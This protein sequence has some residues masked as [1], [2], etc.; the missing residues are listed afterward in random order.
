MSLLKADERIGRNRRQ[1]GQGMVEYII[2]VALVAIGATG[3]YGAFGKSVEQQTTA[4]A[5]GLAGQGSQARQAISGA[6]L[7]GIEA[8]TN[9]NQPLGLDTYSINVME[10]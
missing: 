9:A 8:T 4:I 3:V 1:T 10:H 2:I 5:N 6:A 7:A